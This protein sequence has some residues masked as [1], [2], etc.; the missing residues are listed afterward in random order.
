[1]DLIQYWKIIAKHWWLPVALIAIVG[2][3]SGLT[4]QA[5][6]AMYAAT[7]K[8]NVGLDPVP[9]SGANYADNPLDTWMASEYLMDDLASAVRGADYARRVAQQLDEPDVNLAGAF[10]SATTHRVLSVSITWPDQDQL[11]RIANAAVAVLEQEAAELVG[12][13]GASKP[14]LP[15]I[16]PPVVVP[17]G[18]S[19]KDKLDIPIR[20][21]LALVT[22]I[23]GAFLLDY[24]DTSV[25]GRDEVERM[26]IPILAEIPKHR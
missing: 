6:V 5:P 26:G 8:I 14:V 7:F 16:D 9:Q 10:S 3:I 12:P 24:L 1:M 19:L 23:A 18:R 4:Y 25:R 15:L 17:V 21:G 11:A 2:A 22:G 20:L 13:L